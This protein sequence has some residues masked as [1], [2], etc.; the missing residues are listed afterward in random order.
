MPDQ[1]QTPIRF[2][3]EMTAATRLG[4][5]LWIADSACSP[6]AA[7]DAKE[8][9][10]CGNPT[11]SPSVERQRKCRRRSLSCRPQ[12]VH[13]CR[14]STTPSLCAAVRRLVVPEHPAGK[15]EVG[16]GPSRLC[17]EPWPFR[18]LRT[19]LLFPGSEVLPPACGHSTPH[20]SAE[21]T[22]MIHALPS[23]HLSPSDSHR[24]RH[25]NSA[26]RPLPSPR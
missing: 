9:P 4:T 10:N 21:G 25:P 24:S 6:T 17:P 2:H 5:G 8:R 7:D 20:S 23:A 16:S 26:S 1:T 15:H 18:L 19:C 12:A 22:L 11:S 3:L 13:A 14:L